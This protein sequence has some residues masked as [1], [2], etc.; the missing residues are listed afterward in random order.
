[1]SDSPSNPEEI[2]PRSVAWKVHL[3]HLGSSSIWFSVCPIPTVTSGVLANDKLGV[4]RHSSYCI[5]QRH[6]CSCLSHSLRKRTVTS[7]FFHLPH[8]CRQRRSGSEAVTASGE[9]CIAG[10]LKCPQRP[11]MTLP[12]LPV[13][14]HLLSLSTR[15]LLFSHTRLLHPSDI[16]CSS[17]PQ[18]IHSVRPSPGT[19][20]PAQ[21]LYLQN[22]HLPLILPYTSRLPGKLTD[23]LISCGSVLLPP[24][25]L[26]GITLECLA[27]IRH[28]EDLWVRSMPLML[29]AVVPTSSRNIWLTEFI[30]HRNEWMI[31]WRL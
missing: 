13:P 14:P 9:L 28:G 11:C 6:H 16:P 18:D 21:H 10:I 12:C 22:S 5:Q 3:S 30:K 25:C 7:W 8:A 19:L 24:S 4:T 23:S 15:P 1:M 20:F 26:F 27:F 29:V 17:L 2:E 31:G